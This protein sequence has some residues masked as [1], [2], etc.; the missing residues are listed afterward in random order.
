M[1]D[2]RI[3]DRQLL[4][5]LS[6]AAVVV[7]EDGLVLEANPAFL[8]AFARPGSAGEALA[9]RRL[10]DLEDTLDPSLCRLLEQASRAAGRLLLRGV[11]VWR[12]DAESGARVD[13]EAT[14]LGG[15]ARAALVLIA[16]QG[17]DSRAV[18]E[19]RLID[20]FYWLGAA[21]AGVAH[22]VNNQLT[23][24][25]S[26]ASALREELGPDSPF[27]RAL[28]IIEDSAR[29]AAALAHRLLRFA[30]RGEP[31]IGVEPLARVI[32]RALLLIRHE[33]PPAERFTVEIAEDLGSV[34]GDPIQLEQV[35]VALALLAAGAL[36]EAGRARL[37]ASNTDLAADIVA[38]GRAL[39]RGAYARLEVHVAGAPAAPPA[40]LP[41]V[42][43]RIAADHGGAAETRVL[44]GSVTH[45]LLLPLA[46]GAREAPGRDVLPGAA[47]A[48]PRLAALLIVDD[49]KTVRD[50]TAAMA[51]RLGFRTLTAAGGLEALDVIAREQ[52]RIDLVLLDLVM[53]DLDGISTLRRMREIQP[54]VKVVVS[55]GYSGGSAAPLLLE[56]RIDGTL[57]KPYSLAALAAELRK[58]LG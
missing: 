39:A 24:T 32:E 40:A 49:D 11:T 28:E 18:V 25:L 23:A 20:R 15:G 13:V 45:A 10:A 48:R 54:G 42:I 38:D 19:A 55:T 50:V 37:A 34:R 29:E 31:D 35:V 27:D 21:A 58:A 22:D 47:P 43:R 30:G 44:S 41:E 5:A 8:L 14:P 53:S 26:T 36:G 17:T 4:A 56:E 1:A 6:S 16:P 51:K 57:E 7:A 46:G 9:G 2:A 12:P 3:D 33:L 52:G